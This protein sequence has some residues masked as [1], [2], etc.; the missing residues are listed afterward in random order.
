MSRTSIRAKPY[1]RR[2]WRVAWKAADKDLRWD[3]GEAAR[4]GTRASS[5]EAAL[6]AAGLADRDYS[7]FRTAAATGLVIVVVAVFALLLTMDFGELATIAGE[8]GIGVVAAAMVE[9]V[10][11]AKA[12]RMRRTMVINLEAAEDAA[13][14]S[15]HA[16]ARP[17]KAELWR[18][19]SFAV[20]LTAVWTAGR[21]AD[22][23]ET[24]KL[25]YLAL[26]FGLLAVVEI[27]IRL[28]RSRGRP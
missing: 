3:A 7:I 24:V 14:K 17:S 28:I 25:I 22:V 20:I 2:E 21:L 15:A 8:L 1:S 26:A 27:V 6:L 10:F 11:I 13:L 12:L 5:S 19:F 23:N 9:A 18:I 4:Q 16:P